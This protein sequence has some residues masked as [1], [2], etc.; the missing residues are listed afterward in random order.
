MLSEKKTK[1]Q[2]SEWGLA[3]EVVQV[4]KDQ[5]LDPGKDT[6]KG[7]AS[8]SCTSVRIKDTWKGWA[9]KSCTSVQIEILHLAG[10]ITPC[11]S[12]DNL[13]LQLLE[14]LFMNYAALHYVL[15][16]WLKSAYHLSNVKGT[17]VNSKISCVYRALSF[18][19]LSLIFPRKTNSVSL[20]IFLFLFFNKRACKAFHK[21]FTKLQQIFNAAINRQNFLVWKNYLLLSKC[22]LLFC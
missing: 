12:K 1:R 17:W 20:S 10:Q 15:Q 4:T 8:K 6:W 16:A 21:A 7:C 2:L 9:S 22:T 19:L 5:W 11:R 18:C 13:Q 14:F 3:E